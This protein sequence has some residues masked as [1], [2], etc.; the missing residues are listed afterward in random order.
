MSEEFVDPDR[1]TCTWWPGHPDAVEDP[2]CPTHGTD[3]EERR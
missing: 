2:D 1:C 3:E